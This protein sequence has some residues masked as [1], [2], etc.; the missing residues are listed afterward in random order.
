MANHGLRGGSFEESQKLDV[1]DAGTFDLGA[2]EETIR[3]LLLEKSELEE[4]L[5]I[6]LKD[7]KEAYMSNKRERAVRLMRTM[8]RNKI[9]KAYV[10]AA[11]FQLTSIRI[12]MRLKNLH[13]PTFHK[14]TNDVFPSR[15]QYLD[16][17]SLDIRP[18]CDAILM[19][20]LARLCGMTKT[21]RSP[22]QK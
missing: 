9:F 20:K 8:H 7:A 18:P 21:R 2:L 5:A 22:R 17:S 14:K 1:G 6:D 12:E 10:S 4:R 16:S 3:H 19:R 13:E 11:L 15:Q